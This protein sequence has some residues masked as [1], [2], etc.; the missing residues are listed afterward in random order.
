MSRMPGALPL[1]GTQQL[2][3]YRCACPTG[4]AD[5]TPEWYSVYRHSDDER[6]ARL[7]SIGA[8][9]HCTTAR[10]ESFTFRSSLCSMPCS[11]QQRKPPRHSG[12]RRTLC[13]AWRMPTR[14]TSL[15]LPP[16][17]RQR[18]TRVRKHTTGRGEW[19]RAAAAPHMPQM[20]HSSAE[21]AIFRIN[22][23]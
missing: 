23:L 12:V 3:A 17:R 11:A 14:N 10:E 15:A 2:A 16:H 20:M 1:S 8:C 5:N 18:R 19:L 13:A 22:K 9:A 7:R 6:R 4:M 21:K